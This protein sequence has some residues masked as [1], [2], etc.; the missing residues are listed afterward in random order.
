MSQSQSLANLLVGQ[1]LGG[2]AVYRM[3]DEGRLTLEIS[4][5]TRAD[6]LPVL[7]CSQHVVHLISQVLQ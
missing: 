6:D 1:N 3:V 5:A 7:R 2:Q 4:S